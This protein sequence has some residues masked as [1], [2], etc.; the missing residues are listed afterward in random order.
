MRYVVW[1]NMIY[2]LESIIGDQILIKPAHK[3]SRAILFLLKSD[4]EFIDDD[5]IT[6]YFL[7]YKLS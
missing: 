4:V 3:N 7:K 1:N 2:R 5:K 6:F